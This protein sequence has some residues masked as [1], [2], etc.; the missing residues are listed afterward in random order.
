MAHD[1]GVRV[2]LHCQSC[3]CAHDEVKVADP[4]RYKL[5]DLG[6][7]QFEAL[8]QSL[9]KATAGIA[10]EAWGGSS[11]LGRDAYSEQD[12]QL[13]SSATLVAPVV[14]QAK[15]LRGANAAGARSSAA[16][17]KSVAAEVR[18]RQAQPTRHPA[19][20]VLLTN[21][22]LSAAARRDIRATLGAAFPATTLLLLGSGDVCA[23]LDVQPELRKAFPELLSLRDLDT[24]LAEVVNHDVLERSRAAIEEA[25]DLVPVFVPT[26]AYTQAWQVLE[27]HSFVVLDGAPEMGKTAIAR[28]IGL[29]H[30][31]FGW[32]VFDCHGPDDFFRL[33]SERDQQIFIAD[34]AFGRTEYDPSLGRGWER[35]LPKVLQ[36]IDGAHRLVLTTRK[37]VLQRGLRDMDLAG[38]AERFPDPAEVTV[39]ATDLTL[40]ERARI[41]YRHVK[42]APINGKRL[43]VIKEQAPGIVAD[44]DF[45]PERIRRAIADFTSM[46]GTLTPAAVKARLW[47]AIR[48]PTE[49]VRLTFQKLGT[50]RQWLLVAFLEVDRRGRVDDLEGRFR[51]LCPGVL[52]V[53]F[54]VL[55]DDVIGTFLKQTSTQ[56]ASGETTVLSWIHP[57]YRDLVISEL[58]RSEQIRRRFFSRMTQVGSVMALA[59]DAGR[60]QHVLVGSEGDLR[61]VLARCVTLVEEDSDRA[62]SVLAAL[63]SFATDEPNHKSVVHAAAS[64]IAVS[65]TRAIGAATWSPA[66]YELSE[67]FDAFVSLGVA[68]PLLDTAGVWAAVCDEVESSCRRELMP[69]TDELEQWLEWRTL[70]AL[71]YPDQY[72]REGFHDRADRMVQ[73]LLEA[74][75]REAE[76]P[77]AWCGNPS[78][79]EAR[80]LEAL[81]GALETLAPERRTLV[82]RIRTKAVMYSP[83]S[84]YAPISTP[85]VK[86]ETAARDF[87]V[88]RF[89]ADL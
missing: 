9:L 24:L 86:R 75:Q 12:V 39:T 66:A 34:D 67:V 56:A 42:A 84:N 81:A 25:R 20:Y 23:M 8:V 19:S 85:D 52:D 87:D 1:E 35:S 74:A 58:A 65:L 51:D 73:L 47:S 89:F 76:P 36:R 21:A 33:Y 88:R 82:D 29:T 40:E 68:I 37:H 59:A 7:Y 57:S 44:S 5:D 26:A 13:S 77:W 72:L 48:N 16:L 69:D 22:P 28:A 63:D 41:L 78:E 6:W 27:R 14:F 3:I 55:L 2:P 53:P 15:F 60:G 64:T 4:L 54:A 70:I 71:H 30:L 31:F 10:V 45:T 61:R 83:P 80:D 50:E 43:S 49:R 79:R 17:L 46:E 62:M 32:Q 11:D 38:K 18:V